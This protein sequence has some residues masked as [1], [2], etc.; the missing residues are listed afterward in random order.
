M[1]KNCQLSIESIR[2]DERALAQLECEKIRNVFL[3]REQQT[4]DDLM[5][6]EKLHAQRVN[7]LESQLDNV[8][9]Q[10]VVAADRHRASLT[11]SQQEVVKANAAVSD[12]NKRYHALSL[13]QAEHV[14]ARSSAIKDAE[15][16]AANAALCREQLNK[17]RAP[18]RT[19]Y[20]YYVS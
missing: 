14:A 15:T 12:A 17:V 10:L 18:R 2:T 4:T 7:D 13:E 19:S 20:F 5:Q 6:L 3:R 11:A 1:Q 8:K 9:N 16:A